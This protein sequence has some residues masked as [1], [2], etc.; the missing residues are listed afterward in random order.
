MLASVPLFSSSPKRPATVTLPGLVSD[1][2][3]GELIPRSLPAANFNR[4][5]ANKSGLRQHPP[6]SGIL[7]AGR[8]PEHP[9]PVLIA[10]KAAHAPQSGRRHATTRDALR[11]AITDLGGPIHEF[12][13]VETADDGLVLIDKDVT[14]AEPRFLLGE[15]RAV[16]LREVLI[17]IIATIAD[18]LGEVGAV[19][20]LKIEDRCLVVGAK[21]L[22][23][24]HLSNLL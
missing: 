20:E 18:R 21:P 19:R 17:E 9:K 5:N 4:S 14:D 12:I 7:V 13:Q 2:R 11:D 22:Q 6:R 3:Q 8:R 15:E 10:G 24:E 23:L 1:A 16:S